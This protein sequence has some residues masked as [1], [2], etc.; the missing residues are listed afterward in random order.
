[1]KPV[2]TVFLIVFLVGVIL[3]TGCGGVK[4]GR[5]G[6]SPGYM[7]TVN[8]T[9]AGAGIV[10]L[11]PDGGTY[12]KNTEVT[13]TPVAGEGYEF[14]GWAG[15][16]GDEVVAKG[17][18]WTIKMDGHKQ[19]T[20]TFMELKADQVEAPTASPLG[21]K[22]PEGTEITLT[23]STVGATI[24][25]TV[26]GNEPTT[27]STVY[28]DAQKPVVPAGGMTLKAF[29]VK[30]GMLDSNIATFVYSTSTAQP[31]EEIAH[32]V[33]GVDFKMRR[34][35]AGL[36]F[37]IGMYSDTA[38]INYA[39]WIG[40][41]EVTYE[42]WSEVYKWATA[43]ARGDD[44]YYFQ[45]GGQSGSPYSLAPGQPVT[46][47]S[48]RDAIV[49]CNALTEYY[50][51]ANGTNWDCVYIDSEGRPIRDS[52]DTNGDVCDQAT[53]VST[54][55]GFRLP[56]SKEWELAARY[57]DGSDWLPWNHASGDLSGSVYPSAT[58][59]QLG[60]YAWYGGNSGEQT[61][62]VATKKSNPFGLF[63][64]TGNVWEICFDPHWNDADMRVKRGG[65]CWSPIGSRLILVSFE[66]WVGPSESA[67][68]Y[69]F[70]LARTD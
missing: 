62:P 11:N 51:A 45:N 21:G 55:K 70:R 18:R 52:R 15:P 20:A 68:G 31:I 14:G 35:P 37:P 6:G 65:D 44:R 19:V 22:V 36:T 9:P 13:L 46:M 50:N 54:A 67:A 41:T 1:M 12:A 23:T 40:E 3:F 2:K 60:D 27:G 53:A 61:H 47:I 56:T 34:A 24:Y 30:A 49:W 8:I 5:N 26:D 66:D 39:Y 58:T 42:L 59:T 29:A 25:Y 33:G 57:I 10:T 43:S 64:M 63:D 38:T 28:S 16:N 32:Q 17:D 69:G 48:W 7:L 4:N